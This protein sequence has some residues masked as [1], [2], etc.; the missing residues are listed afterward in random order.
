MSMR[1]QELV[2]LVNAACK[3][4]FDPKCGY[5]LRWMIDRQGPLTMIGYFD[6]PTCDLPVLDKMEIM[7]TAN[8]P[9][10]F[11]RLLQDRIADAA[12]WRFKSVH[13][14]LGLPEYREYVVHKT[15]GTV[16]KRPYAK[17]R[18]GKYRL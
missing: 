13:R 7:R 8:S 16:Q 18:S 10:A 12:L 14:L 9:S 11:I 6:V 1:M 4:W 3:E 5:D 2:D 17:S 15:I